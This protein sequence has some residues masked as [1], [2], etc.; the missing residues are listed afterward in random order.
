MPQRT[1]SCICSS[2]GLHGEDDMQQAV[3]CRQDR[4]WPEPLAPMPRDGT[5][6]VW[7]FTSNGFQQTSDEVC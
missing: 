3:S 5:G 1:Q 2:A 6:G 7:L 4:W